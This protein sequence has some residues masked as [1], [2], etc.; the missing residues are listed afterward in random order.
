MVVARFP[1]RG[2]HEGEKFTIEEVIATLTAQRTLI[3]EAVHFLEELDPEFVAR[4][5]VIRVIAIEEGS[6]IWDL[7]V[8][9]WGA[10]QKQITEKVTGNIEEAFEVDIPDQL[11]PLLSLALL[12]VTYWGLRYAYDRVARKKAKDQEESP[13]PAIHIEGNYN[14]VVNILAGKTDTYPDRVKDALNLSAASDRA[15]IAK[16]AVDFVRPARRRP[17]EGIVVEGTPGVSAPAVAEVP[18]DAELARTSEVIRINLDDAELSIRGTDRDSQT[19]GWRAVIED[20]ERFPKRLPL[21]LSPAVDPESLADFQRVRAAVTV[22]GD[23]FMDGSF[24]PR[25]IHLKAFEPA[26]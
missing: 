15:K 5:I 12:A 18:S 9:I 13:S 26:E 25:R 10:Y 14:T 19:S 8:E 22:E 11:E 4:N 7:V 21:V 24:V 3:G 6:L 20:D 23:Q 16:A 2:R 17:G 1:V